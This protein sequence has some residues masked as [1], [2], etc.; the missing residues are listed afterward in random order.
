MIIRQRDQDIGFLDDCKL[1][2]WSTGE[3]F[4]F[5]Q[6]VGR[7][8]FGSG[9]LRLLVVRIAVLFGLGVFDGIIDSIYT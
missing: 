2:Y 4:F 1:L 9:G 5:A 7:R 6:E 3:L 8:R